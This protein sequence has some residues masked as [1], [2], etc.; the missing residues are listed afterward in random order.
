VAVIFALSAR[1]S[2][3]SR[4]CWGSVLIGGSLICAGIGSL[5]WAVQLPGLMAAA[6]VAFLLCF[7][8]A[9]VLI[10]RNDH[11]TEK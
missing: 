3:R 2:Q 8:Y 11:A 5:A 6:S 7:I 4:S 10:F 1:W 9:A